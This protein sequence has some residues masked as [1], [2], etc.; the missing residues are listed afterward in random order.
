[1]L[2]C[3]RI[4][5]LVYV[6]TTPA[7]GLYFRQ[8]HQ[9]VFLIIVDEKNNVPFKNLSSQLFENNYSDEIKGK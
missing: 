5:Q 4:E 9:I 2:S 7:V 1:M 8:Y 3:L 6:N